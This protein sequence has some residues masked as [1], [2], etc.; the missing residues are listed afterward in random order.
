MNNEELTKAVD[1]LIQLG[2]H[3][4][5]VKH[6]PGQIHLRV[7]LTG[8]SIALSLAASLKGIQLSLKGIVGATGDVSKRSIVI[9]YDDKVLPKELWEL[10]VKSHA[11]PKIQQLVKREILSRVSAA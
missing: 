10:L 3:T 2:G 1:Q 9:N 6:T 7:K 11:N 8:V 5:I 4:E